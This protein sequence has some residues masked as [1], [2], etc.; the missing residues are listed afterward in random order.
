MRET[1]LALVKDDIPFEPGDIDI[2]PVIRSSAEFIAGFVPP[3]YTVVGV[4]IRRFLY[5]LTGQTGAG[6]TAITLRLAASAALGQ[7]FAG[8]ETKRCRVLYAAAENPDDVRMR[9]IALAQHMHFDPDAIEVYF[10]EGAFSISK[11]GA[12]L[13]AEAERVGGDF[14]LVIIDTGPAFF[15]GDDE[16]NRK[17][18]GDHARLMRGLINIIPGGPTVVVNCHPVKNAAADN[19]LP[20]GGGSFLNEV[21]GNLTAA[22]NDSITELHWQGKFRGPDFAPMSFLIKT[23]THQDLKDSDGRL[24]PTVICETLTD[25]AR[26]DIA[27]AGRRD[28]DEILKLIGPNPK[29]S[30]AE[31][32]RMMGWTLHGGEPNKMKVKRCIDA[33][34]KAKL[35]EEPRKGQ[36]RLKEPRRA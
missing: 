1:A 11:V 22:R 30:Y 14:G 3:E 16:N 33:L 7:L 15:E 8:R 21:D 19:L 24:M 2:L 25:Q 17:Q 23:V 20:A 29:A 31:L 12:S 13:R 32:A 10:I 5:S 34:K 4:L 28:E 9:W 36:L 35:V 26:D 27:A 6:K 18:M